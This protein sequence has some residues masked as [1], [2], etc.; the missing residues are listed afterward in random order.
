MRDG[1]TEFWEQDADA[2][3]LAKRTPRIPKDLS[4]DEYG[5]LLT[6]SDGCDVDSLAAISIGE[7]PHR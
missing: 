6:V 5:A 4:S 1:L 2:C 3:A 7:S